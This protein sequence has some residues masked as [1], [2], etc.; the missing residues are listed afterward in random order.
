MTHTH[1][2]CNTLMLLIVVISIPGWLTVSLQEG[3]WYL[4]LIKPPQSTPTCTLSGLKS[5]DSPTNDRV[6]VF[7]PHPLLTGA[8]DQH[9][10]MKSPQT[11][12]YNSEWFIKSSVTLNSSYCQRTP[13]LPQVSW[14]NVCPTRWAPVNHKSYY[15][16]RILLY[17]SKRYYYYYIILLYISKYD[18]YSITLLYISKCC[19]VEAPRSNNSSATKW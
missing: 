7:R 18:Y 2:Q 4:H 14:W 3:P 10:A 12:I 1:T 9:I 15:Y 17:I 11:N 16:S 6:Q 13:S 19:E 5:V 8:S